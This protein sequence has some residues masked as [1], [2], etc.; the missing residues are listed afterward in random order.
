MGL[1]LE[2]FRRLTTGVYVIAA[3]HAGQSDAFTAAWVMQ[4]SFDPLLVAV[5]VNPHHATWP[6]VR[7]GRRFVVS[8]LTQGQ[9]EIARR[10]GTASGRDADKLA[11]APMMP[12]GGGHAVAGAA[13][14]LECTVHDFAD[15]GDHVLVLGRVIGGEV[16]DRDAPLLRYDET[17]NMD[18]SESLYPAAF[19]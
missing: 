4:V 8:V 18:G 2:L 14:W 6:L 1:P 16:L 17:G 9:Q 13:A 3:S 7:D 19:G 12:A 15:A 5:S 11:G 10:F